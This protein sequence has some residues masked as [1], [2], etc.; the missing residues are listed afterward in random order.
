MHRGAYSWTMNHSKWSITQRQ[1]SQ[2][3]WRLCFVSI[4]GTLMMFLTHKSLRSFIPNTRS[5]S[6]KLNWNKRLKPLMR[7]KIMEYS[8][9]NFINY[10]TSRRKNIWKLLKIWLRKW[11]KMETGFQIRKNFMLFSRKINLNKINLEFRK[12]KTKQKTSRSLFQKFQNYWRVVGI[13]WQMNLIWK[14]FSLLGA[15]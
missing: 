11:T 5:S 9:N 1:I 4:I 10:Q 3:I 6:I 13:K 12:G 2:A 8:W 15:K 14:N 7:I